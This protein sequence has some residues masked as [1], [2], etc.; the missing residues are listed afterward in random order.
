MKVHVYSV[1]SPRKSECE[2]AY[3]INEKLGLYGVLDG[4]TPLHGYRDE[5]GHNGAY[6]ASRLFKEHFEQAE[7]LDKLENGIVEAN[8][9]LK[10]R[11]IDAGIDLSVK[12]ELWS[13]C[14]VAVHIR[15]GFMHYAQLG[16]CMALVKKKD[17]A[18]VVLTENRVQGVSDRARAKRERD[19][20]L[21]LNVPDETYFDI[22]IHRM[23]Y[24]R[25]LANTP[26]GYGVA[27][28]MDEAADYIQSGKVPLADVAFALLISD[29]MFHPEAP[30]ETAF[31][32][33]LRDGFADY[34][35][36][37]GRLE[38]D[39]GLD[40]DDRTGILLEFV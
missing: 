14:I 19:R 23:R 31:D 4:V 8:R 34:A 16:D 29:G 33:I 37:I 36:R 24:N 39:A 7:W 40:P 13:T 27:N 22:P 12:H 11:M 3:F 18:V 17:G 2:D 21:G 30:L 32:F 35:E 9:R 10:Q 28:G 38:R 6:I 5:N 26:E 20:A 15:D 25:T 1:K